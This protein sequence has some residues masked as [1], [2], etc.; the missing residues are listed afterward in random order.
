M[1]GRSADIPNDGIGVEFALTEPRFA[2]PA[3]RVARTRVES[4]SLQLGR[5]MIVEN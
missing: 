1:Y 5:R 2:V 4:A 3:E